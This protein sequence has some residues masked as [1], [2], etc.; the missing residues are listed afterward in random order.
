MAKDAPLANLNKNLILQQVKQA[1]MN[2]G[3]ES[4]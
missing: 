1:A 2:S 4:L 3:K